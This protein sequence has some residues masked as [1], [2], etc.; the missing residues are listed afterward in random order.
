MGKNSQNN[1]DSKE[2]SPTEV[3]KTPVK[4]KPLPLAASKDWL[5]Q[6]SKE[7]TKFSESPTSNVSSP[8]SKPVNFDMQRTAQAVVSDPQILH[9][10]P[11]RIT[12]VGAE[13]V[14]DDSLSRANYHRK[15]DNSQHDGG[16]ITIRDADSSSSPKQ[17]MQN[18]TDLRAIQRPQPKK[19]Q[20]KNNIGALPPPPQR[21]SL[22]NNND[23]I[24]GNAPSMTTSMHVSSKNE[25][26]PPPPPRYAFSSLSISIST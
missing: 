21:E 26:P 8:G 13:H 3:H 22:A 15:S 9:P 10:V 25:V 24:D 20:I 23:A 7:W 6:S 5:N 11:L 18:Q 1:N 4:G 16:I 12:P 14:E 2:N 17:S 19:I